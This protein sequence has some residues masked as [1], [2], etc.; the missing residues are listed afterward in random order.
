MATSAGRTSSA[1][2]A[3]M[4]LV[5]G[6]LVLLPLLLATSQVLWVRWLAIMVLAWWLPGA[7]LVAVWRL[8][9]LDLPTGIIVAFGLGLCWMILLG[10][11]VHWLPGPVDLWLLIAAYEVGAIGLLAVLL[12]RRPQRLV[13]GVPT[14]WVWLVVLLVLVCLLR[15][16]G[17]GYHD[18]HIDEVE[19]LRRAR[20][21]IE[22]VD[23]ILAVHTKGPGEIAVAMVTYRALG[24]ATEATARLPFAL[25]S[26]GSV[27]ATALLGRRLFSAATGFWGG[28]LLAFNGFALGLSRIVQYQPAVL[29]L[30]VL[31]VLSAWEFAQRSEGRW[32][33]LA[34]VFGACGV[35][36][37]YEFALLAPVLAV[38]TWAGWKRAPDRGA[39]LR[40]PLWATILGVVFIAAAY[41]PPILNPHLAKTQR[42]LGARMGGLGTFNI[43]T[44]VELGTFY[45]S[46]YFFGGLILLGTAG[47]ILGWRRARRQTLVLVLWFLPFLILLLF[48][49]RL[50]GTH[51]YVLMPSWSLLAALPLAAMTES[52]ALRPLVRG[53]LLGLAVVW[54]TL[55]AGYLYL[56]FFRQAPEYIVNYEEERLSVYVAPYGEDVPLDPRFGFPVQEGWKT[57][58]LLAKWGCL[59]GT[60]SSN[61]ASRI[62]QRWYLKDL[63]Y[64]GP[65]RSPDYVFV[66]KHVQVLHRKYDDSW[67]QGYRQV[68]EVRVRDEPRIEIWA[69]QPLPMS[70]VTY[71]SEDYAGVFDSVQPSLEGRPGMPVQVRGDRFAEEL[72]LEA[73]G[74][75]QTTYRRGDVL[76]LLLVWRPEM[77][78]T[79]DYKFFVHVAD[80]S[81]R[82]L[83]QWD[84]FPCLNLGRTSQWA[85]GE[86]I[87]DHVVM[88]IP[89]DLLP[90]HYSLLV[91]LYDEASGERL[92]GQAVKIATI[93]IH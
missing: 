20:W 12:W 58:G 61:E 4:L 85:A 34:A 64:V 43:P 52:K 28:V 90:G 86:S 10:L 74:L 3:P 7:L 2:W 63:A 50:P 13:P 26:V 87:A 17:L 25:M 77:P 11:L 60:Y 56:A 83:T 57:L 68:G 30:S 84:G 21:A 59:Q 1:S 23:E 15:I 33:A 5:V 45:N 92:G 6:A 53:G 40:L 81:E 18:L 69:R 47:I 54:L 37:H 70:Y 24:T 66:A 9:E 31:A 65:E 41:L 49:M 48:L 80:E 91:G 35:V 38:L 89:D 32:L 71:A 39:L 88:P 44:L 73:A 16:P 82:P 46:S 36:M 22:G 42:Q 27:L 55:S 19:V 62:H 78:L 29:L 51:F 76:H 75:A 14:T 79:R 72:T 93:T 8:P 67:L